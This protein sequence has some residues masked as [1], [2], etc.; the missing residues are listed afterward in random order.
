MILDYKIIASGSSGN[1]V[2]IENIMIDCGIPFGKMREELY[3]C[4]TLLLTHIHGDH[5]KKATLQRIR[6]EFPRI[7]IFGNANVAYHV[8]VDKIIGSKP[9]QL[10]RGN[11]TIYPFEGKHD[12]PVTYFV[13]DFDGMKVFYATDTNEVLNPMGFKFDYI[14]CESNYCTKKLQEIGKQYKT[15]GYDPFVNALR[16][17]S[18]EKCKAFYYM[19]RKNKEVPLLELHKSK[20]FY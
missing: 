8:P 4:N 5:I 17:L 7:R 12:V 16:H 10:K 3:K 13:I 14:F 11:V 20:R 19:N 2:R 1:A 6:N 18:T 15:K 9:F